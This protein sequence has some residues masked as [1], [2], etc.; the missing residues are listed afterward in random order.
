MN[1]HVWIFRYIYM[2]IYCIYIYILLYIYIYT[3]MYTCM[4]MILRV[5][6]TWLLRGFPS[7]PCL[8]TQRSVTW[9]LSSLKFHWLV[10]SAPL[11]NISQ[12][13]QLGLLFPIYGK[14]FLKS[15]K[16]PTSWFFSSVVAFGFHSR[17]LESHRFLAFDIR[18]VPLV[19]YDL[20]RCAGF[21][22]VGAPAVI[23]WL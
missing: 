21:L 12:L 20:L 9:K 15:S 7:V 23:N 10:V 3:L 13:S 5:Q 17:F 22:Q 8:R 18:A 14:I 6:P 2:Y 1:I 4:G 11:K 19:Y 16:P